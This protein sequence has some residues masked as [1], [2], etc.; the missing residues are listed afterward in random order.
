M[1]SFA[2]AAM[3]MGGLGLFCGTALAV[4]WR[5]LRVAE[6]P[7]LEQVTD[8]LPGTNCGACGEPGCAAFAGALVKGLK[9]PSAC[10]VSS[11]EGI[12][13]VAEVLDVEA[14]DADREVAR[15]HCAGGRGRAEQIAEYAGLEGCRAAS[16]VG[17]GGKGCSWGCLGLADCQDACT[18]SAIVM[19]PD[20][21]PQVVV[22]ACTACGDC[23]VA[24]PKDLFE[25]L[26]IRQPLLVQCRV[27]LA[28]E[29]ATALCNVACDACGRCAQDARPGLIRMEGG[30]PIIDYADLEV[31]DAV[32][33]QRCPTG[34]IRWVEADQFTVI[35]AVADSEVIRVRAV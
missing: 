35:Q 33:T 21:L 16:L 7:R 20:G 4:A 34:A 5:F 1:S 29:A 11:P 6:D 12:D 25:L 31:G 32:P 8:L 18:F 30:L 10:T 23:V 17:G 14:G 27:P 2:T 15:L 24:C 13:A 28:G 26:P 3:V 22:D 9:A 19:R